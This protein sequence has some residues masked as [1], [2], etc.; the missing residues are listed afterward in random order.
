[1]MQEVCGDLDSCFQREGESE[2]DHLAKIEIVLQRLQDAGFRANLRKSLFMQKK[3]EYLGY[4]L[5][6][7]GLECQPKKIKAM[8][9]ML[10]PRNVKELKR[11]IGMVNFYR[12]CFEKRSH[13][14][15]P[16]TKLAAKCGKRKGAKAKLAWKWGKKHR[17][18]FE[19][20]KRML[21]ERVSL[22]FPDF[23]KPFHICT[24]TLLYIS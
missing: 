12:D 1:M 11:Y 19:E 17:I 23:S 14:L 4:Q 8:D 9:R 3:I 13:I 6:S 21:R 10:P 7:N 20:T 5:T 24:A 2:A 18:A 15:A 22:A 16:L